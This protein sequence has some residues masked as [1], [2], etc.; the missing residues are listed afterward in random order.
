M[1]D[2]IPSQAWTRRLDVT[3]TEYGKP[4]GLV[5]PATILKML[6]ALARIINNNRK[7][8]VVGFDPI[9]AMRTQ[10]PGPNQGVPLG[11]IGGG[12]IGR[13][14]R[15]DFRRWSL[16]PGFIHE[17]VIC[18]DQF[19]LYVQRGNAAPQAVTLSPVNP[20]DGTLSSWNWVETSLS[21]DDRS[22]SGS[23]TN[24]TGSTSSFSIGGCVALS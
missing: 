6:P 14:W 7:K 15:G 18:A 10:P 9:N 5:S 22:V 21:S 23:V 16:R 12:S 24:G 8:S 4:A 13:G 11:G 3:L 2:T 1:T 17:K 20:T 19:S